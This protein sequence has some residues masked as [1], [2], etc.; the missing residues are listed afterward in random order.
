VVHYELAKQ[1]NRVIWD[2]IQ[3]EGEYS[4]VIGAILSALSWAISY[5]PSQHHAAIASVLGEAV[6]EIIQRAGLMAAMP[7]G[8]ETSV[9]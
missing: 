3:K 4:D 5:I 6:P 2:A 9:Q 7:A 1:L 8:T